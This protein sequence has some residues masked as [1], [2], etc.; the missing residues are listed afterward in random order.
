MGCGRGKRRRK[1]GVP[2]GV[3]GLRESGMVTYCHAALASGCFAPTCSVFLCQRGVWIRLP[4]LSASEVTHQPNCPSAGASGKSAWL[5]PMRASLWGSIGPH[6]NAAFLGGW[7]LATGC[8]TSTTNRF[9]LASDEIASR[10]LYGVRYC[11]LITQVSLVA[12]MTKR[13]FPSVLLPTT[14]TVSRMGDSYI[15]LQ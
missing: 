9:W 2:S 7:R 6:P 5:Q 10:G 14:R 12:A 3:L 8:V 15:G 11:G 1:R 4:L 13:T